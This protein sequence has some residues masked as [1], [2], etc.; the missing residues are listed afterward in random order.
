M[1]T[2]EQR[3]RHLPIVYSIILT[4]TLASA[5]HSIGR[6]L[7]VYG[8]CVILYYTIQEFGFFGGKAIL[9]KQFG[10]K[11][12]DDPKKSTQRQASGAS[13]WKEKKP[14]CNNP[15]C[16]VHGYRYQQERVQSTHANSSGG[17][18]KSQ[19][20][21]AYGVTDDLGVE[22]NEDGIPMSTKKTRIPSDDESGAVSSSSNVK[23]KPKRK[24]SKQIRYTVFGTSVQLII[25]FITG[26]LMLSLLIL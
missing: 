18:Y 17:R 21:N 19:V 23:L 20:T 2:I 12:D 22:G 9:R 13:G 5:S 26:V 8:V 24:Q 25:I 14:T 10:E 4:T 1:C 15:Y 6:G 16:P 3:I 11:I 7:V